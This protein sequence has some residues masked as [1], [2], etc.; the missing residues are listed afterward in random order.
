MA[1][2]IKNNNCGKKKLHKSIQTDIISKNY[3]KS[4]LNF[5]LKQEINIKF[6]YENKILSSRGIVSRI[7]VVNDLKYF[8]IINK[9]DYFHISIVCE[10][11]LPIPDKILTKF[12]T[13]IWQTRELIKTGFVQCL[14]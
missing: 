14:I 8:L 10:N 5:T 7:Y 1:N 4:I 2:K 13:I 11:K 3:P 12:E 9:N 6:K